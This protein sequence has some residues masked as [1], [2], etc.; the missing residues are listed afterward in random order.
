MNGL[1]ELLKAA[2][3]TNVLEDKDFTSFLNILKD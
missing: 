2:R 1:A 3:Q